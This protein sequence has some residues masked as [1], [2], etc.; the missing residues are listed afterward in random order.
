MPGLLA[1]SPADILRWLLVQQGSALLALSGGT[2]TLVTDP[3]ANQDWGVFIDSEPDSPD[4]CVTIYDTQGID[5]GRTAIDRERQEHPGV[6][7]RVRATTA[8]AGYQKAQQIAVALD[9]IVNLNVTVAAPNTTAT[10]VVP[11]VTRK[12]NVLR[13]GKDLPNSKRS[14][15]TINAVLVPKQT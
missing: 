9:Q 15:F 6:Q 1:H 11:A 12:N 3:T 4:N 14:L 13:I 10:Y 2:G 8:L 5:E 7:I